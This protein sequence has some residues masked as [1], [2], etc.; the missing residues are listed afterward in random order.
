MTTINEHQKSE[1]MSLRTLLKRQEVGI[2]VI[3]V[4]LC[5]IIGIIAPKFLLPQNIINILRQISTV[6]VMAVGQAMV[7][8]VAGIDLSVGSVLALSSCI[9]A[10]LAR[11]MDPWIAMT[12]AL[13]AGALAGMLSGLLVV[14]IGITPFIATLGMQMITRGLA[15]LIT[16]GIPVKFSYPN[17]VGFLGGGSFRVS[18]TLS[19]PVSIFVMLAVYAI[20]VIVLSKTV[21]GRSLYAVGDNE[22]SSMLSGINAD[23]IKITAYIISGFLAA[24]A[25][26]LSLG[27][28]TIAEASSGDGNELNV[29]AAVVIGGVSMSGGEGSV[30]GILIGAAIMGVIRNSFILLNF[31]ATMQT[32]TIGFLILL[33]VGIDSV[34]KKHKANKITAAKKTK[35]RDE[36]AT[37]ATEKEDKL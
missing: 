8:I 7:I 19:I 23:R 30:V 11:S 13:T 5:A 14:K 2:F 37:L 27:N 12:I 25:G 10:V 6:G 21:F 22:R 36:T 16:N 18:E 9:T 3:F 32:I 4:V 31:K 1:R 28:L 20:G 33:A 35:D 34:T 26:I 17:S 24:L 15:F 29:I